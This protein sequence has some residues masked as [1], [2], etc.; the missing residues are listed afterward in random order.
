[1]KK[2]AKKIFYPSLKIL[3]GIGI[4]L[5]TLNAFTS[6][7]FRFGYLIF[8]VLFLVLVLSFIVLFVSYIRDF[9]FSKGFRKSSLK[10][11]CLI[12]GLFLF[13][14]LKTTA[15]KNKNNI[16]LC[17]VNDTAYDISEFTISYPYGATKFT[18]TLAAN[19]SETL[20]IQP[21]VPEDKN[22]IITKLKYFSNNKW[23]NNHVSIEIKNNDIIDKGWE[24]VIKESNTVDLIRL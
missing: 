18:N 19:D 20:T 1:M 12:G 22:S 5:F 24:I 13:G 3:L 4:L 11:V 15:I 6:P 17:L 23:S 9:G 8:N 21:S 7:Y 16:R 14:N 2:I 10:A